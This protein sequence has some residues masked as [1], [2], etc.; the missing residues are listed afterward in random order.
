M[1]RVLVPIYSSNV[2]RKIVSSWHRNSS[3]VPCLQDG[4]Q[5]NHQVLRLQP[6]WTEPGDMC[7]GNTKNFPYPWRNGF[8][9]DRPMLPIVTQ[10]KKSHMRSIR[11][12]PKWLRTSRISLQIK[13]RAK[14]NIGVRLNMNLRGKMTWMICIATRQGNENS[15][16]TLKK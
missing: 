4:H 14:I 10:K 16:I 6:L 3:P 1:Y 11:L 15:S 5:V 8:S 7:F 12:P 2:R 9:T 13:N